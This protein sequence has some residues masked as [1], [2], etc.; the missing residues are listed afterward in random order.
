MATEADTFFGPYTP[1]VGYSREQAYGPRAQ[2]ALWQ[3]GAL[4]QALG[5]FLPHGGTP[6]YIQ[7]RHDYIDH[8]TQMLEPATVNQPANPLT[9][10]PQ[11]AFSAITPP[12][13]P[14]AQPS[15]AQ[16]W[17]A[18]MGDL[19]QYPV[20]QRVQQSV[21]PSAVASYMDPS[22]PAAVQG[23]ALAYGINPQSAHQY[24]ATQSATPDASAQARAQQL[25]EAGV[26][27]YAAMRQ[28][29]AEFT[30]SRPGAWDRYL[31]SGV[32]GID[33]QSLQQNYQRE[34]QHALMV[35]DASRVNALLA[36]MGHFA[37]YGEQAVSMGHDA[38]GSPYMYS[39]DANGVRRVNDPIGYYGS[40]GSTPQ[41]MLQARQQQEQAQGQAAQQQQRA[42]A[43]L[44]AR[45]FGPLGPAL[46][47][48]GAGG[49]GYTLGNLNATLQQIDAHRKVIGESTLPEAQRA[50]ELQMLDAQYAR[51]N[52]V[53]AQML[54]HPGAFSTAE[55]PTMAEAE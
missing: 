40:E 16:Q 14:A 3:W 41:Q 30:M 44:A 28:A 29:R 53:R 52:A 9:P 25:V 21:A 47:R 10:L 8:Q 45:L 23:A 27:P 37:P 6:D 48:A 46:L 31:D 54:Q 32:A 17:G 19:S 50:A 42:N 43:D 26:D 12:T 35:N 51:V 24:L 20:R 39:E 36:Q 2:G 49:N 15:E 7:H 34:L 18:M 33:Q 22:N 38:S 4:G 13:A 1:P 11:S 55:A 5:A